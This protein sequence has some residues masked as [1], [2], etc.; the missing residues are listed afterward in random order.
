MNVYVFMCVCVIFCFSLC[1]LNRSIISCWCGFLC[2]YCNA[3]SL[4]NITITKTFHF[5]GMHHEGQFIAKRKNSTTRNIVYGVVPLEQMMIG[6]TSFC[7][8]TSNSLWT[9]Y[10]FVNQDKISLKIWFIN[11]FVCAQGHS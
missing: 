5:L 9:K 7:A 2:I 1:G 11:Q 10:L 4:L 8:K 3:F 6:T